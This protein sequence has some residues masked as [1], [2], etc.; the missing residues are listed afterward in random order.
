MPPPIYSNR[1][2]CRGTHETFGNF[3][4]LGTGRK[5]LHASPH[6]R[7]AC[8]AVVLSGN[9]LKQIQEVLGRKIT[10]SFSLFKN[11]Y[12]CTVSPVWL[13]RVPV[14]HQWFLESW[15]KL[16]FQN[17]E[18][19]YSYSNLSQRQI[20]ERLRICNDMFVFADFERLTGP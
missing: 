8:V 20:E 6:G 15:L 2:P 10:N 18:A 7:V 5:C 1:R 19:S 17:P 14:L 12:C 11:G 3:L 4:F 16:N 13:Q 9:Q